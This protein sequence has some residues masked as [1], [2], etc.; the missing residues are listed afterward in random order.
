MSQ[1]QPQ[2]GHD[3]RSLPLRVRHAMWRAS[4]ALR[5]RIQPRSVRQHVFVAGMQRS[6][7]NL[8]M[9]V[10]DASWETQVFHETDPRAF[11]RY[12]MRD[13]GTIHRLAADSRAP[14]FVIKALCELDRIR[15]LMDDFAPAKCL[16]V[17]RDWRDSAHSAI[18]SFGNFVPQ[19][20]RLSEGDASDWRGRGMSSATRKLLTDLYRPDASEAEGAAV[21]WLYRNSLFFE[22]GLETDPR[23]YCV[24]YEDLVRHPRQQVESVYRFLGL[25]DFNDGV[26]A[27]IHA[28]SV[29]HR[30]PPDIS[31]GVSQ[32]CDDLLTRFRELCQGEAA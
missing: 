26:A 9:D 15:L 17:V 12:E 21:M 29:R 28:R 27:R 22:Q 7:T 23:A 6:G 3:A 10:L 1:T 30:S 2:T 20:K 13:L 25:R 16:W 32:R 31:P 18:K 14:V 8:L 19:W 5:Q 24:F 4:T 11:E